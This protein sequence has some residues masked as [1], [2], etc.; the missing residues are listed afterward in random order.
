MNRRILSYFMMVLVVVGSF[1]PFA[2]ARFANPQLAGFMG[3]SYGGVTNT[4]RGSRPTFDNV[5]R[6]SF[7]T[8]WPIL[9]GLKE[10]QCDAVNSDFIIGIPPGGCSPMVVRSDLL[11]EQNVPVFCQLSAIRVNPLIDV[12]TIKSISFKGDYPDEVAGISFH[13]A[14][15]AVRSYRTLLGDP[16]DENIGYVV[17]VLKRQPDERNLEEYISGMLTATVRY[18]AQGAFGTGAAEYY[19]EPKTD[20]NWERDAA[21]SSFWAGKGYLR[22]K[23]VDDD[24][25]T[26]EVLT[27]KD[28]VYRT[29]T[30]KEGETSNRIY[31]PGQYCTAAMK[32]RLNK[33]D[34]SEDM[35]R[36]NIDGDSYWVR[37]GSKLLGGK[38]SV[39]DLNVFPG[40]S[41]TI[42]IS[43]QGNSRFTLMLGDSGVVLNNGTS[44][45]VGIGGSLKGSDGKDYYLAYYGENSTGGKFAILF[46]KS[47][48]ED[49]VSD[50]TGIFDVGSFGNETDIGAA[51]D[52]ISKFKSRYN[53]VFEGKSAGKYGIRVVSIGV[54][55]EQEKYP[56]STHIPKYMGLLNDTVSTLIEEFPSEKKENEEYWGEEAL[57]KQIELAG[58][59][60]EDDVQIDLIKKFLAKYPSSGSV[61]YMRDM[62][63]NLERFDHAGASVN[64]FVNNNDYNIRVD[65]FASGS[66]AS[67]SVTIRLG[68][69]AAQTLKRDR[70]YD[71][72]NDFN[73][74]NAT[75]ARGVVP[76]LTVL[77]I[78]GTSAEFR[79]HWNSS[80]RRTSSERAKVGVG[81]SSNIGDRRISVTDVNVRE[82]AY[83]S[84]LPEVRNTK[85]EANFTFN[86]GIE[87]RAIEISPEKAQK[88]V[89]GDEGGVFGDEHCFDFEE[90]YCRV[91]WRGGFG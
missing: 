81:F 73:E 60:K 17:I 59:A 56:E 87:K 42:E 76:R 50:I 77:D 33:I 4:Y 80:S 69:G 24:S 11:A 44:I 61:E 9:T 15:A 47:V 64:V 43:C 6:G 62:K 13:P 91:F 23:N 53:V 67:D 52:R 46:D 55:S 3:Q 22:V 84:L 58:K 89:D 45:S 83:V 79:Y 36:V 49:D 74:L 28:D 66:G 70:S 63:L 16:I 2:T 88:K 34:N 7:D 57:Y 20:E 48:T 10:D 41:G 30:L 29:V 18:D 26:I 8:Y 14:R 12:S 35:A 68:G 85:T 5:Y 71:V 39:R 37:K 65:G 86:I 1:A 54:E 21:G 27:D 75:E 19:L 51:L 31:Y 25:A 38:C 72:L 78:D 32:L 40:G 90:F 82:V